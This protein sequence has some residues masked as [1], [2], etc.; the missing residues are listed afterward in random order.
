MEKFWQFGGKTR[1]QTNKITL[2]E[3][4]TIFGTDSRTVLVNLNDIII[5]KILLYIII[6]LIGISLLPPAYEVCSDLG[7]GFTPSPSHNTSTGGYPRDWS[8]QDGVRPPQPGLGYIP[9]PPGTG[10]AWTCCTPLAVSHR[11][12]VLLLNIIPPPTP[13]ET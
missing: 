4:L 3:S 8:G 11:R 9:P 12:T 6:H 13:F 7:G 2:Y 10:Y 1:P 5:I